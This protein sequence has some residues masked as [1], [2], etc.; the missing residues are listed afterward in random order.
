MENK[1][2]E[3]Y[4]SPE[5]MAFIK[6]ADQYITKLEKKDYPSS[7]DEVCVYCQQKLLDKS[8]IE[9]LSSYR[10][11]LNDTT[12]QDIQQV[13]GKIKSFSDKVTAISEDTKF[14]LAVFGTDENSVAIQPDFLKTYNSAISDF[15]KIISGQDTITTEA[16]KLLIPF[17]KT[18]SLLIEKKESHRKKPYR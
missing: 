11:V 6:A 16:N 8:S 3:L 15:K 2:V 9:L 1:G 5:F 10:K 14:H 12:Q 17:E 18:I 7:E 4:D 13:Q